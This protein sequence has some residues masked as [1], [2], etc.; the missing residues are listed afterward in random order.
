MASYGHILSDKKIIKNMNLT[1]IFIYV[2]YILIDIETIPLS[3]IL[4]R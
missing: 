1:D 4:P 3:L 2:F